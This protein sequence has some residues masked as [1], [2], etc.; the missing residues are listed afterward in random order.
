MMFVLD[1]DTLTLLFTGHPR[2]TVRQ[3]SVPS[4]EIAITVITWIETLL[5]RFEF[6][7]KAASGEELLRAQ[8]LLDRTL[9]PLSG[10]ETI[11]PV[12]AA[13][14]REFDRLLA[15]RKLKKIGR[16]DVVISSITLANKATLV[17]RNLK[18][19][20]QVPGLQVESW[21]D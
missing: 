15:N 13:A 18:H 5:G 11:L 1:A 14:A 6:L 21:A 3:E 9:V 16:A 20:R 12:D 8:A 17:T 2:V 19:F 7:R 4:A 10:V